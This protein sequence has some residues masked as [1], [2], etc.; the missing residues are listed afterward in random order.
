M[1]ISR[2]KEFT[3][4]M[5]ANLINFVL[6]IG[7]G[8][9]LTSYITARAGADAYGFVGLAN[10]IVGYAALITMTLNSVAS[11]FMA[12][13][14]HRGDHDKA[15]VYFSSTF[16]ADLII[17]SALGI[18]T[19][20]F[21]WNLEQ[22]LHIPNHLVWDVKWLFFFIILN[23]LTTTITSVLD[24]ATFITNKLYLSSIATMSY[25]LIRALLML[26]CFALFPTWI[27]WVG[28]ATCIGNLVQVFLKFIYNRKL[29]PDLRVKRSKYSWKATKN[30]LSEGIWNSISQ[31]QQILQTGVS[32]LIANLSVSALDTGLLSIAQTIP[33]TLISLA[34]SIS[35]LF[36]P[37]QTRLFAQGKKQEMI[38]ETLDAMKI[39]GFVVNTIF[40]V[41]L[42]NGMDFITLWQPG[43]KIRRIYI[44]MV[45]TLLGVLITGVAGPIQI[46]PL[47]INR[48]RPYSLTLVMFGIGSVITT[49]LI[50]NNTN[51]GIFAIALIPGFFDSLANILFVP[52]Y[53]SRNMRT[54]CKQYYKIYGIYIF[55][56]VV[57]SIL[58]FGTYHMFHPTIITWKSF[59]IECIVTSIITVI[60]DGFILLGKRG[61]KVL[62]ASIKIHIHRG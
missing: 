14:F 51:L 47:I 60:C 44:L 7:I 49:L 62:I 23:F 48:L 59:I 25:T 19:I 45:L 30:M 22:I 42:I 53:V 13:A 37:D 46:I 35:W 18:A 12:V 20:P 34:S 32:L 61:R 55:A 39:C 1:A 50:E 36:F 38:D 9:V 54:S 10:N 24:S 33:T 31:L 15:D 17:C 41:L 11:R 56:T 57:A 21:I 52:I 29:T 4:N 2:G 6:N 3:I 8:F 26:L 58:S 27:L 40:V 16:S 5:I 28:V 43:Q